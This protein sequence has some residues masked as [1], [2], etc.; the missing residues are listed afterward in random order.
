[1][2]SGQRMSPPAERGY[3]MSAMFSAAVAAGINVLRWYTQPMVEA[4]P[5]ASPAS[6]LIEPVSGW[7]RPVRIDMSV[8]LPAPFLPIRARDSP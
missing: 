3:R 1:M 4:S 2:T 7:V 8:D 5:F 6:T